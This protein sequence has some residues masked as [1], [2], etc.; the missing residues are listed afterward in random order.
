LAVAAWYQSKRQRGTWDVL[1]HEVAHGVMS[2]LGGRPV[3]QIIAGNKPIGANARSGV[4]FIGVCKS[5]G[6]D[7]GIITHCWILGPYFLPTFT[8]MLLL[9]RLTLGGN[10]PW[11]FDLCVGASLGYHLAS[12]SQQ[13]PNAVRVA[14]A[15]ARKE[16]DFARLGVP[17]SLSFVLMANLIIV[18]SVLLIVH[19]GWMAAGRFVV[20]G[21]GFWMDFIFN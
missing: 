19:S 12:Y 3:E 9:L 6:F 5:R 14:G 18:P 13:I 16:S 7:A 2:E 17:F 8:I 21:Q 11:S 15:D 1:E 20:A 4:N 10:V